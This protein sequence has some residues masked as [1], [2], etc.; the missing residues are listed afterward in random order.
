LPAGLLVPR[1]F[2]IARRPQA[3]GIGLS[4]IAPV[5]PVC[6]DAHVLSPSSWHDLSHSPW[7]DLSYPSWHDLSPSSWPDLSPSSWPDVLFR[8]DTSLTGVR[9]TY[10]G[11]CLN[12]WPGHAGAPRL[13]K[14]MH[15][16]DE[17]SI[18]VRTGISFGGWRD[19]VP[20]AGGTKCAIPKQMTWDNRKHMVERIC[21]LDS[22]PRWKSRQSKNLTGS[23]SPFT[24]YSKGFRPSS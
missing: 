1:S 8:L 18:P 7:P 2:F 24:Y 15:G 13:R 3:A 6:I 22:W 16:G 5:I 4:A 23:R 19:S 11:T 9:A 21:C 17:E 14:G 12:R 20:A 10:A